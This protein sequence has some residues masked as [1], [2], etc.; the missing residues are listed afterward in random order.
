MEQYINELKSLIKGQVLTDEDSLEHYSTDGSIFTMKPW[1]IVLPSS[2]ED[3]VNL[4]KWTKKTKEANRE[5]RIANRLSITCRGKGTDQAGGPINDGIILKFP[6]H[7][8]KIL[9]VGNDYVCVEP[10]ALWGKVNME[11]AKKGHFVPCYPASQYFATIVGGVA[12]NC[13]GEKSVKYGEARDYILSLKMIIAD[14]NEMEIK[15]LSAKELIKKQSQNNFE[16]EIYRKL[17]D[18]LIA[19]YNLIQKS[20]PDVNKDATGYWLY[21]VLRDE[22][23]DLNR[24]VCGSQGTF[25]IITEVTLKTVLKPKLNGLLMASFD[26]LE[27]TGK[28]IMKVLGLEPSAFEIVDSFLL[29]MIQKAEPKIV[30]E[31]LVDSKFP[32]VILLIEFDGDDLNLIKQKIE[33]AKNRLAGLAVEF[34]EAFEKEKQDKLWAVRRRAATVAESAQGKKKA[35]PFIEDSVVH[36]KRLSEYI[37]ELYKILQKYGVEFAVWGHAGNGNIHLQ[38]FLDIGDKADREKLFAIAEEVYNLVIKLKGALSGEHNDGLMRSPFLKMQFKEGIYDLFKQ[39]K[40]I[41]DPLNIFNPHKKV[42]VDLDFVKRYLRDEYLI[43][44]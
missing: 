22:T 19:N 13:A 24:L 11:L 25:G 12:N 14:G 16:G 41:F 39:V 6:G 31:L 36:P 30:E 3:I 21:D 1:A 5:S 17:P 7:L 18:L 8:D 26:S 37:S 20:K 29:Q 42:D 4:V 9:E 32:A 23:V 33:G 28:A 35:L 27:T 34:N 44:F 15:P 38:P 2:K 10:G 43:H 40:Q